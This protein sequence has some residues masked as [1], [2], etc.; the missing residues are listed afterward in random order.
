MN[1]PTV[2]VGLVRAFLDYAV[3]RGANG[4][5]LAERAGVKANELQGHDNRV[6]FVQ[7]IALVR[8]GK[9][10]CNDSALPLRFA[11]AIDASEFSIVGLLANASET[12]LDALAQMNR[13]GQLVAEVEVG[14]GG[15][16]VL[17]RN[18]G[19]HWVIDTRLNPNVY[20]EVTESTFTRMICGPRRFL[21]V[22]HIL[23]AHV[24]HPAP[25]HRAD[26]E[27]IWRVPI[28]FEAK[29][30]ALR[31][32][33]NIYTMRVQLQPR[34]VFGVLSAH[35]DALL[36]ALEQS[37]SVRGAVESLLM[38]ILHTGEVSIDTIAGR[39]G[40]SRQTIYRHLKAEGV[41][42][43]QVLDE[44][45]HKLALYYLRGRKVSVN[46]TAYLVGFSD[47]AA[48]SRAF[49]RWT[50]ASPRTLRKSND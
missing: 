4:P 22:P 24:T 15:R 50:G 36:K 34:Y 41:T 18:N 33:P 29:H 28:T 8:A 11:E 42:F 40:V 39:M 21:P 9:E 16:W 19:A 2:A 30:N 20:P 43:E 14:P 46:E 12:M 48:F 35:A 38:P 26:Y 5:A 6:P 7:Y 49:K 23:E 27:R 32:D 47:A 25:A 13:Y 45:R 44:L 3:S 31:M 17:E 10:I 37:K 1:E